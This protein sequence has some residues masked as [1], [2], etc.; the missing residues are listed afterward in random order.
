MSSG[1][2]VRCAD[3][4][5]TT[6]DQ[7]TCLCGGVLHGGPHTERARALVWDPGPGRTPLVTYSGWQ[8]AEARRRARA[9]LAAGNSVGET[10]TDFAVVVLIDTFV[11]AADGN[12]Q[13]RAREMLDALVRP[14]VEE[15]AGADL[16]EADSTGITTAVGQLHILCTLCVAIL[17]ALSEI[18]KMT[19][20][21]AQEIAEA[22]VRSLGEASFLTA[23]VKVVLARALARAARSVAALAMGPFDE[24]LLRICG[25]VTCPNVDAHRDVE[26][27]CLTPE[28]NEYVT[29]TLSE[30]VG[31]GFP[32]GA[33]IL[34]NRHRTR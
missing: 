10:S 12:A 33:T 25:A 14:F 4:I 11:L 32:P 13:G 3:A 22:V 24:Q 27:Y 28:T 20:D 29:A 26:T 23:V 18:R 16:D 15:I 21:M 1:H 34:Q 2:S 8:V 17:K 31:R 30:W 6:P 7:C 19:D 9:A 5:R